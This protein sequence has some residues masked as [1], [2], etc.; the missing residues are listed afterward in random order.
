MD[1]KIN[2]EHRSTV[3]TSKFLIYLRLFNGINNVGNA[4]SRSGESI[5]IRG[6]MN[7]YYNTSSL[8]N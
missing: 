2:E 8:V 4:K 1:E 6:K 5:M 7:S 3:V